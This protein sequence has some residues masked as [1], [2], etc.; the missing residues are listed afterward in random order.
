M[1]LLFE[2][3]WWQKT[4]RRSYFKSRYTINTVDD[5]DSFDEVLTELLSHLKDID[6]DFILK[7]EQHY[8][9][10]FLSRNDQI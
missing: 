2:I 5:R 6:L 10:M 7:Q 9:T 1:V 4:Q 3:H 8:I